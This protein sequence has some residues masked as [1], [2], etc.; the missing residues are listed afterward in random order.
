M[1]C[2]ALLICWMQGLIVNQHPTGRYR[3]GSSVG[4]QR[5]RPAVHTPLFW[6]S[7]YND[8]LSLKFPSIV[9]A[10]N[11][12]TTYSCWKNMSA[13]ISSQWFHFT[14]ALRPGQAAE[15]EGARGCRAS[16]ACF[17]SSL[18]LARTRTLKDPWLED[19]QQF[20]MVWIAQLTEAAP[21]RWGLA[22]FWI[23]SHGFMRGYSKGLGRR[24]RSVCNEVWNCAQLRLMLAYCCF[25]GLQ[26]TTND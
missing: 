10:N 23:P 15:A 25:S 20:L 9:Y 24:L 4:M 13:S 19:K 7:Q 11:H 22:P 14:C 5:C 3:L 18:I 26:F 1:R 16:L 21:P 17:L 8:G 12:Q 6:M 2:W